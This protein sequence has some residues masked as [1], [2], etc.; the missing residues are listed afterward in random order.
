MATKELTKAL[1]TVRVVAVL[2]RLSIRANPHTKWCADS[3]LSHVCGVLGNSEPTDSDLYARCV[4][5]CK[6]A[7][8]G[9]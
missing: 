3:L 9:E 4:D 7:I 1:H 5:A 2:A 8:A 6:R